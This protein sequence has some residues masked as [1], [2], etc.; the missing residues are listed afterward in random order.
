MNASNFAEL[1]RVVH[2][3]RAGAEFALY[4]ACSALAL[5]ADF[6][7]FGL[8]LRLG[9]WFPIA[10]ALGFIVGMWVAYTL[11]I[12]FVFRERAVTDARVELML[13]AAIGVFG[14]LLTEALLWLLVDRFRLH[15]LAAK[16]VAAGAVFVTNFALRKSILF[17]EHRGRLEHES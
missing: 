8:G 11:S 13:F 17:T 16:L 4:F 15:A 3:R 6:T 2:S 14:L 12:R 10:A 7:L 1:S 5:A 9:L